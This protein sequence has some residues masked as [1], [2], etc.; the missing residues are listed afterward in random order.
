MKNIN[1]K[2]TTGLIYSEIHA[3][4]ESLVNNEHGIALNSF[5]VLK[6]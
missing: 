5:Q 4:I 6:F 3:K 1:N 2:M